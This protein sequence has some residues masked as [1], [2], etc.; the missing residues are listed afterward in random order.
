MLTS[1]LALVAVL[2][3]Y[4]VSSQ[5]E[6][7]AS[8]MVELF[9]KKEDIGFHSMDLPPPP[10]PRLTNGELYREQGRIKYKPIPSRYLRVGLFQRE[11]VLDRGERAGLIML[12]HA[13]QSTLVSNLLS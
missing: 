13:T 5:T 2:V 11:S 4:I 1:V 9:S 12:Y 6:P 7:K 8:K 10:R 3:C